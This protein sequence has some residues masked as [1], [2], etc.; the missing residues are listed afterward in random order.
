MLWLNKELQKAKDYALKIFTYRPRTEYEFRG[1]LKEKG[2]NQQ[3]IQETIAFLKD[4]DF[5]NDLE[6]AKRWVESRNKLKP[7]GSWRLKQELKLKG[8]SEI[9]IDTVLADITTEGESA[10]AMELALKKT[11]KNPIKEEKLTAFLVRRGFSGGVIRK[12]IE[13]LD[14][15][16]LHKWQNLDNGNKNY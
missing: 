12:T 9:I 8:I 11:N 16:R 14:P 10:L 7:T 15:E 4:Y 3:I 5:I 6:F 2:F 13:Q 1:K